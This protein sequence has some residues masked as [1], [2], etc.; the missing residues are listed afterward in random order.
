M[1][2][3][4][5]K[6]K[7]MF[8]ARFL[9]VEANRNGKDFDRIQWNLGQEEKDTLLTIMKSMVLMT[10]GNTDTIR[11]PDLFDDSKAERWDAIVGRYA[12]RM[13]S[14]GLKTHDKITKQDYVNAKKFLPIFGQ[15]S[16]DPGELK[17]Y[18]KTTHPG[19]GNEP[20]LDTASSYSH[21][22]YRGLHNV[23]YD[24]AKKIINNGFLDITRAVST[25]RDYRTAKNFATK[26]TWKASGEP[27]VGPICIIMIIKNYEDAGL[28]VGKLSYFEGEDEVILSGKLD[29]KSSEFLYSEGV[30]GVGSQFHAK[31][32]KTKEEIFEAFEIMKEKDREYKQKYNLVNDDLSGM[33]RTALLTLTCTHEV[34]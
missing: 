7:A 1:I 28:A 25:S 24:A 8:I 2:S 17:D 33:S 23:S 14:I 4:E 34:V 11:N 12:R 6:K 10:S 31:T 29:I 22:L 30:V 18:F 3:D 26:E 15:M 20:G 9:A 32:H 21:E 5:V 16:A 13:H 27:Y 19:I